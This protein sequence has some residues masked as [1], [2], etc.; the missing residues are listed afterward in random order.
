MDIQFNE[1]FVR[2]KFIPTLQ[3]LLERMGKPVDA[4]IKGAYLSNLLIPR[5]L[6]AEERN[7][8]N[9]E[10]FMG[11]Q[12]ENR[13]FTGENESQ[14][15]DTLLQSMSAYI[16]QQKLLRGDAGLRNALIPSEDRGFDTSAEMNRNLLNMAYRLIG[17]FEK[18]AAADLRGDLS[19]EDS[20]KMENGELRVININGEDR[21]IDS[22]ELDNLEPGAVITP[23]VQP[24]MGIFVPVSGSFSATAGTTVYTSAAPVGDATVVTV[25]AEDFSAGFK[26]ARLESAKAMLEA[27]GLEVIRLEAEGDMLRG[28]VKDINGELLQTEINAL[29]SNSDPRKIKFTFRDPVRDRDNNMAYRDRYFYISQNDLQPRFLVNGQRQ[30][31]EEVYRNLPPSAQFKGFEL[32]P[33]TVLPGEILPPQMGTMVPKVPAVQPSSEKVSGPSPVG[34]PATPEI[35]TQEVPGLIPTGGPLREGQYGVTGQRAGVRQGI[36]GRAA[37]GKKGKKGAVQPEEQQTNAEQQQQQQQQPQSQQPPAPPLRVGDEQR[38]SQMLSQRKRSDKWEKTKRR[39]LIG[40]ATGI[41][42]AGPLAAILS[43]LGMSDDKA[44]QGVTLILEC[45]GNACFC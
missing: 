2:K 20:E 10:Y 30:P 44:A 9:E 23:F 32:P 17:N 1:Q 11:V 38:R 31:A 8:F 21:V 4:D 34:I 27:A 41:T 22:S 14:Y 5:E 12:P 13:A 43:A 37:R 40:G 18:K 6:N 16:R 45:L 35:Q 25:T 15:R 24:S 29:A 3:T 28:V 39:L 33:D 19:V 26:E 7:S 42:T 36:R